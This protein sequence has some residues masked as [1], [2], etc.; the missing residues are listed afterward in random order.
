MASAKIPL[1]S[2]LKFHVGCQ[3]K[4]CVNSD[5]DEIQA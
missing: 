3:H 4:P 2:S 5:A 1:P